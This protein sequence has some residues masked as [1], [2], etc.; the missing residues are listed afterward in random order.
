MRNGLLFGLNSLFVCNLTFAVFH[1]TQINALNVRVNINSVLLNARNVQELSQPSNTR[2]FIC[3]C[4]STVF[5]R[6]LFC[7]QICHC[8]YDRRTLHR[9][10]CNEEWDTI[11]LWVL[12]KRCVAVYYVTSV[13]LLCCRRLCRCC[14]Y[15]G[16]NRKGP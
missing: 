16:M 2:M 12:L 3:F 4:F 14:C 6:S 10:Q 7:L 11:W 8:A 5:R 9:C 13:L 1:N 15:S